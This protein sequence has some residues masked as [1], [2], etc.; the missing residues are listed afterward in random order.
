MQNQVITPITVR[1]KSALTTT[2]V[3]ATEAIVTDA[4]NT[5]DA[6]QD[7]S[8]TGANADREWM[9]RK[10]KTPSISHQW[11]STVSLTLGTTGAGGNAPAGTL[12][13]SI[14]TDSGGLPDALLSGSGASDSVTC[15]D[16][17]TAAAG[18]TTTFR[19]TRDCPFLAPS[20]TY[21]LVIKST[22]YTY[23]NGVTE[24]RWRTDA[25]G[26]VGESECAKFDANATPAWTVIGADV[27]ADIG[28]NSD[29]GI[30]LGDKNQVLLYVDFTIGDSDG[31]RIDV[32]FSQDRVDWHQ[33]T[34]KSEMGNFTLYSGNELEVQRN[35][36]P[37]R[38]AF[39]VSDSYMRISTKAL[40]TA[41]SAEIGIVALLGAI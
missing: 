29:L 25:N 23:A 30:S 41:T 1:T 36:R 40:T 11:V 3:M 35:D 6:N 37:I 39:P 33:M 5:P 19:W 26:A 9:A 34:K 38:I 2:F 27:G 13:A 31:A 12:A 18:E 14:Y 32:E 24:V 17:T 16:I 10:F 22:G 4:D 15:L 21:W 7:F 28:I 20:T 8:T